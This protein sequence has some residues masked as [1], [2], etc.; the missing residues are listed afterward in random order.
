[1]KDECLAPALDLVAVRVILAM[2]I[3]RTAYIYHMDSSYHVLTIWPL[4]TTLLHTQQNLKKNTAM[5]SIFQI[6]ATPSNSAL[7]RGQ[8]PTSLHF[9]HSPWTRGISHPRVCCRRNERGD[10]LAWISY[11]QIHFTKQFATYDFIIFSASTSLRSSSS[12]FSCAVFWSIRCC[13]YSIA[14]C[15]KTSQ[16]FIAVSS[17]LSLLQG[18]CAAVHRTIA[19]AAHLPVL[20]LWAYRW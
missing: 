15:T 10:L 4:Y 1:M 18:Q 13:V 9:T 11:N 20:G 16:L 19:A 5:I 14:T 17:P 2:E 8:R 7:S 3:V 12:F 6:T